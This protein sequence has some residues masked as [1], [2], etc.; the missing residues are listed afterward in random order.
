VLVGA[1]GLGCP[2]ALALAES[3]GPLELLLVDDDR[4]E[5]SNLS[6][7]LLFREQD[8]GASKAAA[9]ARM[10]L[11]Y[12]KNIEF[13]KI[14]FSVETAGA[15]LRDADVVLDATDNFESRFAA[16]D[17]CL[18]A[19][20]P[21]VHGAALGWEGRLL[22]ILPGRSACL[23][24]LFEGPPE[25][26][27]PT[28]AEAGV[29]SPLCGLVGAAMARAALQV[30]AGAPEAGVLRRWDGRTGRERPLG[31]RRDPSCACG[32]LSPCRSP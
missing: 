22:T 20:V 24:C 25:G 11:R 6:R 29:A 13:E 16:N 15:L 18:A 3:G 30:L 17:A 28:C 8:L 2:A 9:G 10:L 26:P 32:I 19:G 14:R 31:L 7:Q 12:T 23:R 27:Q 1:G 4:V 21:L 5:A